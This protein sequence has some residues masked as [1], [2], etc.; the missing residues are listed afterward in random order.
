MRVAIEPHPGFVVY[1]G[2]TLL[3]LR[4][5]HAVLRPAVFPSRDEIRAADGRGLGRAETA[6][7]HE[8][9][10]EMADEHWHDWGRRSL[11]WYASDLDEAFFVFLNGGDWPLWVTLPGEP[12]AD[13]Y[14]IVAH[15]GEPGELPDCDLD[16]GA[17]LDVPARTIL[18]ARATVRDRLDDVPARATRARR[19]SST[20]AG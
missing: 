17:T 14:R 11:G 8:S 1:N 3:R 13:R 7:F 5:K 4:A 19:A 18:V 9:G 16:P 20:R 6:W 15:T 10:T 2:E 12:W